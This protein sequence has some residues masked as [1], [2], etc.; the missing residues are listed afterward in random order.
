MKE[1]LSQESDFL[2]LLPE[3]IFEI[4]SNL[5]INYLNDACAHILGKSKNELLNNPIPL[6]QLLSSAQ[7]KKIQHTLKENLSG[8]HISGNHYTITDCNGNERIFS[9]HNKHIK[10]DGKVI[11]LRCIAIDITNKEKQ[12]KVIGLQAEHY[13][14]IFQNSPI[15]YESLDNDGN[16]IDVNPMW[17]RITGYSRKSVIGKNIKLIL[18]EQFIDKFDKTF[19]I[20]KEKGEI[21]NV[22][23][24]IKTKGNNIIHINYNGKSERNSKGKFIRTHCVFNDITLQKK[25]EQTLI[26]S[27][28]KLRELVAT[29]DKFFSIILWDLLNSYR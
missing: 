6:D 13:H 28:I 27:E 16:F 21:N 15:A 24:D 4:D 29:K 2:D 17:E 12:N 9:I 22:H 19:K 10:E 11:A 23:L 1:A 18:T 7:Q 25:A 3:I 20:L 14:H 26:N 5:K 8:N